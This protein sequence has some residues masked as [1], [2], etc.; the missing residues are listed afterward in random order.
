MVNSL[1]LEVNS[2]KGSAMRSHVGRNRR[3]A[4]FGLAMGTAI[5]IAVGLMPML[6]RAAKPVMTYS[7]TMALTIVN[8][9]SRSLRNLY[10]S[11]TNQDNWG[12]DQLNSSIAPGG[13][14]TLSVSCSAADIKVIAEDENGCFYYQVVQCGDSANWTITSDATPDCGNQ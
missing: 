13:S 12:P 10:L 9:S 6:S 14:Q 5:L 4:I 11:P 2:R 8:N 7:P 1:T 3:T